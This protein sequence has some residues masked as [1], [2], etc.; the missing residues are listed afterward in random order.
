MNWKVETIGLII[1]PW[2]T[3]ENMPIQPLGAK[4]VT[5][6]I[7][8][9]PEYIKGLEEIDGFSHL[10]LL[11][12]FHQVTDY[13]L[14][15]IPFMDKAPKGVFATR[16]PKRPNAIGISTVELVKVEGNILHIM[17]VDM[18]NESPLLDIKPFFEKFDNQFNTRQGW[19]NNKNAEVISKTKSDSRFK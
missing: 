10:I 2:E 14:S 18:L 16:S 15:V 5:G 17:G 8:L 4:G 7:E 11:Y 3:I 12:K 13:E 9:F 1:T 19:L 6:K